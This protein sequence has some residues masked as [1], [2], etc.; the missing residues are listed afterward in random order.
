M[1]HPD[2]F[3]NTSKEKIAEEIFQEISKNKRNYEELVMLKDSAIN[4]L[5][6]SQL[7]ENLGRA[8]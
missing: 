4:E 1:C 6:D 8:S 2:K 7:F 5:F 3:V